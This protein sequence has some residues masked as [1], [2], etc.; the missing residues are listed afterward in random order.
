LV[1]DVLNLCMQNVEVEMW[2][3]HV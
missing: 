1:V 2:W 3:L